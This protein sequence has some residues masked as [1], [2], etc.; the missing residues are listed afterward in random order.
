LPKHY[1]SICGT[2]KRDDLGGPDCK[3]EAWPDIWVPHPATACKLTEV[4]RLFRIEVTVSAEE[5]RSE[6]LTEVNKEEI[7]VAE[8]PRVRD[9]RYM[10]VKNSKKA[11]T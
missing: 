5:A 2:K 9:K 6:Y 4:D 10:L 8:S 7:P 3:T 1:P 11:I